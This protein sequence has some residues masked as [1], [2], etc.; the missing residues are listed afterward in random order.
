MQCR[1]WSDFSTCIYLKAKL[2][3]AYDYVRLLITLPLFGIYA[4]INLP[5]DGHTYPFSNSTK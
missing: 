1:D 5:S 4:K 2:F 3:S